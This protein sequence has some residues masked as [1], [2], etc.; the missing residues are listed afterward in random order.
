MNPNGLSTNSALLNR[1]LLAGRLGVSY[2]GARDYYEALGYPRILTFDHY[3]AM[4]Q[5]HPVAGRAV[6]YPA[7][8][9]WRTPPTV[10]DGDGERA[11]GNTRF[12]RAW[13]ELA[14]RLR[15]WHYAE[16]LDRLAGIGS[17]GVLLMG[18]RGVEMSAGLSPG[19]RLT[20][21]DILYLRPVCEGDVSGIEFDTRATSPRFG[22]PQIYTIIPGQV[23]DRPLPQQRVHWTLTLHVAENISRDQVYGRPRLE[24]LYNILDDI[25]KIAG[26]GAEATWRLI[27]KGAIIAA[28]DGYDIGD[29]VDDLVEKTDEYIHGLRRVLALQGADLSVLGG[30]V[31][32][33]T[34]MFAV[35]ERLVAAATDIPT[36]ILFGSER[37]ELASSQDQENY[38]AVIAGRQQSFAEPV[39]LR[40]FIDWCR[41][42]GALPAPSSAR[43]TV[44][45][46]GY[47][48]SP[49][50][51]A[52]LVR[53]RAEAAR[54]LVEAGFDPV[55]A[56]EAAGFDAGM[57]QRLAGGGG[58]AQ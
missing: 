58:G 1:A 39:I 32:D 6:D 42:H 54:V 17:F 15:F 9:T 4:Y 7:Q 25:T 56:A 35:L 13:R 24:R 3:L 33:P 2:G 11:S 16:R 49:A 36:R 34:G 20:A 30:E 28:R 18:V 47:Q 27:Y 55:A 19:R 8:Q 57:A 45:W 41:Q 43:Y 44:V 31:V 23:G 12:A 10:L 26:G 53:T 37:G 14:A 21:E 40:P 38:A 46:P 50:H 48:S 29:S 5:R 51:D 52:D 22:L